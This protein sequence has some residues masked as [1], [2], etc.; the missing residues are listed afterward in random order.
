MPKIA[1]TITDY[2]EAPNPEPGHPGEMVMLVSWMEDGMR[3]YALSMPRDGFSPERA[4]A[5]VQAKVLE[6][7]HLIGVSGEVGS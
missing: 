4:I 7:S 2:R 3:P 5:A 6:H 1:Y